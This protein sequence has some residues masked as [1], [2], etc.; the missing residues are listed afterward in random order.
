[1]KSLSEVKQQIVSGYALNK[2]ELYNLLNTVSLD[3]LCTLSGEIRDNLMGSYF[4]TCSIV[5]ARSGRCS[6]D[7]KWCAQSVHYKT[8]AQDYEL[9]SEEKCLEMAGVNAKYGVNKFSFVTSGKA[10][11]NGH[12]DTLCGYA[13]TI[14][15]KYPIRLCASMGLLNKEQLQKLKDNGIERYH[16]N[17]ESS[18]RFF[19]TLCTTH[20]QEQ[21]INTIRAAQELGMDV[22]SGGIIGMGETLEDRIDLAFVLRDLGIKSIPLNVLSPIKGTPLEGQAPLTDE[23]ILQAVVCYRLVN[24][25]AYIRFAGGRKLIKHIERKAIQS[26][27]NAA[28]VGDLLTTIGSDVAQDM[29]MIQELNFITKEDK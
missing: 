25:D 27:V 22:C 10:L 15:N 1:M 8:D 14:K 28:I 3:E 16:C 23:E 6:E 12:I 26:G 5:N 18:P 4:D 20:T 29:Q 9:I 11:T 24:P 19:A 2:S 7:C 21:K 13:R 17:L